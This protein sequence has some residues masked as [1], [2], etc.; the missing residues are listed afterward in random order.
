MLGVTGRAVRLQL[1]Q[2]AIC[3]LEVDAGTPKC[4]HQLTSHLGRVLKVI[5]DNFAVQPAPRHS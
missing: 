4:K 5:E 3:H 1:L 2:L